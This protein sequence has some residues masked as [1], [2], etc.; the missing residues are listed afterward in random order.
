M[1]TIRSV[2]LI[3]APALLAGLLMACTSGTAGP[4]ATPSP[5]IVPTEPAAV[6]ASQSPASQ[7][8]PSASAE[9]TDETLA[10]KVYFLIGDGDPSEDFLPLVPVQRSVPQTEDAAA[11]AMRELLA[12]PTA[13]ERSGSYPG[14]GGGLSP[15][16][17]TVPRDASLLGIDIQDGIATVDLSG[18]FGAGDDLV[19]LVYRQAQ[20]VYTLT[21]FPTVDRVDFRLDGEPMAAIEGHEGSAPGGP[22]T[23]GFYFDQR[24]SVFVDEPAWGAIVGDAVDVTGETD[25]DAELRFALVDGATDKILAEQAVHASCDP[26]SAPD[27]WGRFEAR[28]PM[29]AGP[30]PAD[31]RL[32]IW[33][34]PSSEGGPIT[35]IDYPLG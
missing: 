9:S 24:R 34:P 15:L 22:A 32:R 27:S 21:Q 4:V 25:L 7:P 17:T 3:A 31:L 5:E 16:S 33:E 30:R 2:R 20:V 10:L 35:V 13:D 6:S 1:K 12:G 18:D 8:V 26:C 14:R 28:L 23:R 11:A 29:P 19:L